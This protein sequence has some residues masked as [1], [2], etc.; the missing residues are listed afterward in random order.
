[1][2]PKQIQEIDRAVAESMAN[3][4]FTTQHRPHPAPPTA[5]QLWTAPTIT[6]P[7]RNEYYSPPPPHPHPH[8]YPYH[9]H[10]NPPPPLP[11]ASSDHLWSMSSHRSAGR[12]SVISSAPSRGR[13]SGYA[14]LQQRPQS[15]RKYYAAA[16]AAA[17]QYGYAQYYP[18][19]GGAGGQQQQQQQQQW[20]GGGGEGAY[21]GGGEPYSCY[22]YDD[23]SLYLAAARSPQQYPYPYPSAGAYPEGG[24]APAYRGRFAGGAGEEEDDGIVAGEPVNAPF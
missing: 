2:T 4:S 21:E 24:Y 8:P 16:T 1:M 10:H 3:G 13:D 15:A 19:P 11:P 20:G 6:E 12:A 14:E 22:D 9:H 17:P 5:D 23:H 7:A 18:Q